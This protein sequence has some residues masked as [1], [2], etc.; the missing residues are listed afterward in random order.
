ML[1]DWLPVGEL[2]SGFYGYGLGCAVGLGLVWNK[3]GVDAK[4]LLSGR[5]EID[6]AGEH[7]TARADMKAAY[8]PEALKPRE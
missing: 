7:Y 3:S 1:R 6:I 2:R 5:W 4:F 8:D